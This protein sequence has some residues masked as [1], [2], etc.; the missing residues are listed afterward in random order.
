MLNTQIA[1]L[2]SLKSADTDYE[3]KCATNNAH[4]LI[5]RECDW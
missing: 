5:S 3:H 4:L 2:H 1:L